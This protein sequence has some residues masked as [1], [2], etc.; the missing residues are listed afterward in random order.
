MGRGAGPGYI[1]R[2]EP[3]VTKGD[4]KA[5][6]VSSDGRMDE[7]MYRGRYAAHPCPHIY[8]CVHVT[9]SLSPQ[10]PRRP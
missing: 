2:T 6:G 5:S 8:L 9:V 1:V 4:S 3:T 10:L 7:K